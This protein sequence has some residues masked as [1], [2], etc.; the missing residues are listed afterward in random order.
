MVMVSLAR[1]ALPQG[2][3]HSAQHDSFRDPSALSVV[4]APLICFRSS[5]CSHFAFPTDCQY[6]GQHDSFRDL[7]ALEQYDRFFEE[8]CG[9]SAKHF[10]FERV[11][12]YD[13]PGFVG[14]SFLVKSSGRSI[15]GVVPKHVTGPESPQAKD[16]ARHTVN[17]DGEEV[18][19]T[20]ITRHGTLDVALF[21]VVNP[22]KDELSLFKFAHPTK[23]AKVA[24]IHCPHGAPPRV[25]FGSVTGESDGIFLHDA[26]SCAGSS[27][28]IIMS[29]GKIIGMHVAKSRETRGIAIAWSE[30]DA[31][32]KELEE[33]SLALE[34]IEDALPTTPSAA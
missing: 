22:V 2:C 11:A 32:L 27:G 3:E 34:D 19:V 1:A 18:V 26:P 20:N 6:S 33:L 23:Y 7:S 25:S 12:Q 9:S 10:S 24:L 15:I 21:K 17:I 29:G 4:F 31:M 14:T 16:K 13:G 5:N 8:L 30:V 28:G